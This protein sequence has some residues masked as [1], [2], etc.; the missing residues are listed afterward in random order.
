MG[1]D[2]CGKV[3]S[4][5]KHTAPIS[6]ALLLVAAGGHPRLRPPSGPR[7]W[8]IGSTARDLIPSRWYTALLIRLIDKSIS[9]RNNDQGCRCQQC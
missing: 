2:R 7:E 4:K 1:S 8:R 6:Q 9:R 3:G 5:G